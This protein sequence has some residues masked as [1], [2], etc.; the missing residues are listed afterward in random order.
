MGPSNHPDILL[1]LGD[2]EIVR[3][4]GRGGMG[5]VYEAF[6][7][8]R[9]RTVALKVM[10]GLDARTI[11][12]FKQV[13]RILA[14]MNHPNL[15]TLYELTGD[16]PHWF[17]TMELVEGVPFL[18]YVRSDVEELYSSQ[19]PPLS[20]AA[21]ETVQPGRPHG[22]NAKQLER[23]RDAMGQLAEGVQFLHESGKLHRDIKPGNV[24]VTPQGRVVLLD[25]GL[26]IELDPQGLHESSQRHLA[27]TVPYMSPEQIAC[28]P[29]SPASDWYSV[30]VML[31]EALTGRLPFDGEGYEILHKKQQLDPQPPSALLPDVPEDLSALCMELLRRAPE[32]R[33]TGTE[34]LR[35]ISRRP[36]AIP[37][38]PSRGA[39]RP[40]ITVDQARS[41][42]ARRMTDHGTPQQQQPEEDSVACAVFAPA[43]VRRGETVLL[44]AFAFSEGREAE[45]AA[46]AREFDEEA[47]RRGFA[48][49]DVL[50]R[51]GQ[52]LRFHLSLGEVALD[53]AVRELIW[54]G[55]TASVQFA[56]DIPADR[57]VG[58]LVGT[59]LISTEGVPVGRIGFKLTVVD[60]PP[61]RPAEPVSV[62]EA[63]SRFRKAFVSYASVDRAEVL[64]R[65]QM[66]RR[67]LTDIEVFQDIL[68]LEP[69]DR[70]E[71]IL[72]RRIDECDIFLLFWSSNARQSEWVRRE[73]EYARKRQGPNGEPP[74]TILPVLIEGPPPPPP[75]PELAHL[76]FN[77]YLLYLAG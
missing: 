8:K 38:P 56:V 34:V 44:Q 41:L 75:P 6:D 19:T 57:P 22:L 72:Y 52:T 25:F 48:S 76:H 17:F 47:V 33:P 39:R 70:F 46:L 21:A 49:L 29:L 71:P 10:Q 14:G 63:A 50:L 73:I 51:R 4:L 20:Q 54:M 23:L 74:P 60:S 28:L 16:G 15:V 67:P 12:R 11:L 13:F 55:R 66:L 24:L 37:R 9:Q 45:A 43:R 65:V 68:D 58:G 2:F 26:A 31:Y 77:D 1:R 3:E 64:R 53:D 42:L 35:R 36:D 59:L 61:T 40:S 7:R 18:K 62:G 30:G 69:G 27:G 5:V 32:N